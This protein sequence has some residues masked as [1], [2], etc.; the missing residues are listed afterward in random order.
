ML[1]TN[2]HAEGLAVVSCALE[3]NV[4]FVVNR[5]TNGNHTVDMKRLL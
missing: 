5:V 1:Q 3:E 4:A 2:L